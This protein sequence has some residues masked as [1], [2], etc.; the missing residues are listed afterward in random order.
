MPVEEKVSKPKGK[1]SPLRI[2]F[3]GATLGFAVIC[4]AN[5]VLLLN[6]AGTL[7]EIG[8]QS[9]YGASLEKDLPGAR[10]AVARVIA[11]HNPDEFFF[12]GPISQQITYYKEKC[13][14]PVA[15]PFVTVKTS[16]TAWIPAP[17]LF[18]GSDII[19]SNNP[20]LIEV[21]ST[22]SSP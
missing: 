4:L 18:A 2:A 17:Q 13:A 3:L 16:L 9:A 6:A 22:H 19:N 21:S 10:Q 12:R 20:N 8:S 15:T 11:M 5:A 14:G 1:V 7:N